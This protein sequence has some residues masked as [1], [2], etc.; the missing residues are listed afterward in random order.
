[1]PEQEL[2]ITT[3]GHSASAFLVAGFG[4]MMF[5][6]NP[7]QMLNKILLLFFLTASIFS[8]VIAI[9]INLQPGPLARL[10][11][12]VNIVDVFIAA[13]FIHFSYLVVGRADSGKWI[14]R[15]SY[16]VAAGLFI[17]VLFFPNHFVASVSEKMFTKSFANPGILYNLM[18]VYFF[19]GFL[20]AFFV[21]VKEMIHQHTKRRQLGYILVSIAFGFVFG[22]FD[23][24]LI[25]DIEISPIHGMFF[26][27]S[28][29]PL[30]YGVMA[31]QLADLRLVFRKG[32]IYAIIITTTTLL[33]IGIIFLNDALVGAFP[34]LTFWTIPA[35]VSTIAFIFGH[36]VWWKSKENDRIKYEFLTVAA[37]KLRTPLTHINL[38]LGLLAE[39]PEM[40]SETK[41]LIKKIEHSNTEL[42][43][44]TN[45]LFEEVTQR[46]GD[47]VF[48]RQS[49]KLGDIAKEVVSRL[50]AR[51]EAKNLNVDV[52]IDND[53]VIYA[54]ERR[55]NAVVHALLENSVSYSKPGGQIEIVIHSNDGRAW[56][57]IHDN[58]IGVSPKDQKLIFSRFYRSEE[59]RKMDTEGV[60]LGLAMARSFIEKHG[61]ELT[62]QSKGE[63]EGSTFRFWVPLNTH[64]S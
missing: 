61:G 27:L 23:F 60:G 10:V 63:G 6:Q 31:G 57:T 59:A 7:R 13:T 46:S 20:I 29:L 9:G 50:Q 15:M 24:Y 2:F 34:F 51:I 37:H 43:E 4:I 42:I 38:G 36:L 40:T 53:F 11:W 48:I 35:L 56:F 25:Y 16:I 54:N 1:M 5:I 14:I 49:I 17:A 28:T 12:M 47:E 8:L 3:I 21:L 62:V 39:R 19:T 45:I 22:S 30:A 64:R 58:G 33:L 44:L 26:G 32:F 52:R 55:I 18:V 41:Y